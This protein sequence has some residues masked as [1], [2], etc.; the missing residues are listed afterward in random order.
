MTIRK[1]LILSCLI[2]LGLSTRAQKAHEP[3]SNP[4][5]TSEHRLPMHTA[6]HALPESEAHLPIEQSSHYLSLE[7]LWRFK[8]VRH[9]SQ[10]PRD[11]YKTTYDDRAWDEIPVPGIWEMHGYGDPI[12]ANE[13]YPWHNQYRNNPPYYPDDNNH[14]GSYRRIIHIPK[15]WTGKDIH[16]HVGSATSNLRLWVNGRYVGYSEDSKLP[17]EFD[18]TPYLKVGQDNLI[19]MQIQRWSTGTYLEAQDMWRLSGIARQ[20]YLYAREPRGLKDVRLSTNL[21]DTYQHGILRVDLSYSRHAIPTEMELLDAEGNKV[22][23]HHFSAG[24][25]SATLHLANASLWSAETPYLYT[26]RIK[27]AGEVI[28][29]H[30]GFRRVEIRQVQLLVNGK[31]ILIKGVNRHELDPDGGYHVSRERMEQD[32]KLMKSLNINAVRTSHYPCDP[33][34]YELCDRYGLYVVAEANVESHGMG[35]GKESLSHPKEWRHAHVERN[36]RQVEYLYNHPS[37]IIWSTGNESGP[38]INFGHAYDAIRH[39]DP[40]RPIQY[41]RAELKYTDLYVRMYR[42]P[43]EIRAYLKDA[44][45]PFVLCEYAHAMGNS[46][47][48]FE[49][50]WTLI[51]QEPSLQGG[52]VWDWAD[53]S[54]RRYTPEGKAFYAY[55]GDFNEYDYKDD[56]NFCNNGIVSPDRRL[57]PH[58]HEVRYQHQNIWTTLSDSSRHEIE[59]FNE[60]FFSSLEPYS[61]EWT[62]LLDGVAIERGTMPLPDI[63]PQARHRLTLPIQHRP[64]LTPLNDLS[65]VVRYRLNQATALLQ[66][67]TEM[68]HQQLWI[69][70]GAYPAPDL[71]SHGDTSLR[72]DSTDRQWLIVRGREGLQIDINRHTGLISRWSVRG[73]DL[74]E[75]G[76]SLRPNFWR[77]PTDNDMGAQLQR[78]YALW[79]K[80]EMRLSHLSAETQ[81]N[82]SIAIRTSLELS[83]LDTQISLLYII[84]PDGTINY[85]QELIPRGNK[86]ELPA[87]FRNGI[88]LMMPRGYE[89]VEYYGYGPDENYP[90]RTTS[91]IVSSYT[92]S[93]SDL[94]YPYIRPQETGARTGLKYYRVRHAN[95]RGIEIRAPYPLQASAL[96]YSLDQ[97]DG[98]PHKGQQHSELLSPLQTTEL[99]VDN[100]HMGLGCYNSWGA[101]PQP[102]F[103]LPYGGYSIDL[104]MRPL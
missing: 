32:I 11:F 54:L 5:L 94:F 8:W 41:E 31:P 14:V 69:Q 1:T 9:L 6:F 71:T 100:H 72:L 48:G 79:R 16:L 18:L 21:D 99:L 50:Y 19:A 36:T 51:R 82:G 68:A 43:D 47:G 17:A 55:A 13:K 37:I 92:T 101:L 89:Q 44:P 56:N 15:G 45:K 33:H 22:L 35:Y 91:Q 53:Q 65:I 81:D 93:V 57:N 80:P 30:I 42:Q 74:L 24:E 67:G 34:W 2:F 104:V 20:V 62:L 38:G 60:H 66:A 39:I 83:E 52:F 12:Y 84:L 25:R 95:G 88:R 73:A 26:A 40:H 98:Y 27:A 75:R 46:M 85:R 96:H 7:G 97:L 23:S 58:A 70:R 86:G 103:R 29:Q 87:L 28:S 49:E 61:L 10:R 102:Q 76:T 77:A 90:D 59:I 78:R 4:E 3:H 63:A 64:K